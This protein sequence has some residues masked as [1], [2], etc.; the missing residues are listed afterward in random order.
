MSKLTNEEKEE[1]S[2]TR[3]NRENGNDKI[4]EPTS[5]KT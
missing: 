2:D 5:I 3:M 4:A 1:T